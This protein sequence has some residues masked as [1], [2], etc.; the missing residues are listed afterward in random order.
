MMG[1]GYANYLNLARGLTQALPF[2]NRTFN[3]IVSTFP[4]NYIFDPHTLHEISRVLLPGGKLVI[5]LSATPTGKGVFT[6]LFALLFGLAEPPL[7]WQLR[8]INT[9]S[10]EQLSGKFNW[11]N[12]PTS[13]VSL[14][15]AEKT[16]P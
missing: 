12:L 4:S 11:I 6:K 7:D 9:L 2:P 14:I 8:F 10:D 3:T 16:L 1:N 13:R 5:V 15:I